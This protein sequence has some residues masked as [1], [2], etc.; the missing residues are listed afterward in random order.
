[1]FKLLKLKYFDFFPTIVYDQKYIE[2]KSFR[3]DG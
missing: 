2:F 1:M 3:S